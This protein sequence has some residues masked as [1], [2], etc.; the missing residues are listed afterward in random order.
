[1]KTKTAL[2]KLL[3]L[4]GLCIVS[5]V[6]TQAQVSLPFGSVWKYL[7]NGSDQGTAWGASA[8]ND[9][10]WVS[11]V[12]PLGYSMSGVITSVSFGSS[13]T[14]KYRTTYYRRNLNV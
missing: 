8:Y 9:S 1:M 7:D 6:S 3:P 13:S 10:T 4:V 12:A 14:N 11:G 2:Q 5:I